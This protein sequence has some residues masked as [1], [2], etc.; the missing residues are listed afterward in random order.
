MARARRWT[1][2]DGALGTRI[3]SGSRNR[4]RMRLDGTN[5]GGDDEGERFRMQRREVEV[6]WCEAQG[7]WR[8][9][10]LVW[11]VALGR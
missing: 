8:N 7:G 3:R 4:N 6:G 2:A 1:D 9:G 10:S 5:G 11:G